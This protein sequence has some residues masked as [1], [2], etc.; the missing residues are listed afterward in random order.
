MQRLA[1][2]Q[3]WIENHYKLS[4]PVVNHTLPLK[5]PRMNINF[6]NIQTWND[7]MKVYNNCRIDSPF[8]RSLTSLMALKSLNMETLAPPWPRF[9]IM[10]SRKDPITITKSKVFQGSLKY[11]L[12]PNPASLTVNSKVKKTVKTRFI[13]SKK[14]V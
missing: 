8:A 5:N 4:Y 12:K 2:Y 10:I 1:Q 13:I 6:P 3:S 9:A 11:S 14:E 7:L